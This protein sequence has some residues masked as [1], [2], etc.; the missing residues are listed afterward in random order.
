MRKIFD[1]HGP[2]GRRGAGR[3]RLRCLDDVESV[4]RRLGVPS[5]RRQ[6]HDEDSCIL[7]VLTYGL[8]TNTQKG[9]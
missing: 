3:P 5:W 9:K 2:V 4:I 7:P 6:A 8:K 1:R